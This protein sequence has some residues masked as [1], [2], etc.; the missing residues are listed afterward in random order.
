MNNV[1]QRVSEF[2]KEHRM[3]VTLAYALT[4]V[5]SIVDI[6]FKKPEVEGLAQT[7]P[8]DLIGFLISFL[9]MFLSFAFL[10]ECLKLVRQN[11]F[12]IKGMF[13]KALNNSWKIL[14]I[15]LWMMLFITLF[16]F[17]LI[18]VTVLIAGPLNISGNSS[19]VSMLVIAAIL[20]GLYLMIYVYGQTPFYIE[21]YEQN[22]A[23]SHI[24]QSRLDMKGK[25]MD[26]FRVDFQYLKYLIPTIILLIIASVSENK[27]FE[28][29]AWILNYAI[30]LWVVPNMSV[31]RA[32]F[33]DEV[34][35]R[36][37]Y[38]TE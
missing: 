23:F 34:I 12:S 4:T 28:L 3:T 7:T 22:T 36:G 21:D 5:M 16:M 27:N 35:Y 1:H 33:Y 24:K 18:F 6:V 25:K 14:S 38:D 15:N 10:L 29:I 11:E 19:L 20:Y 31:A 30:S 26:L 17:A 2:M 8:G 13:N 37:G 32:M 9:L